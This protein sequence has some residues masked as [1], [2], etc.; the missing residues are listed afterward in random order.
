MELSIQVL[1]LDT[2]TRVD[3]LHATNSKLIIITTDVVKI[4]CLSMQSLFFVFLS[5]TSRL[6]FTSSSAGND[7]ILGIVSFEMMLF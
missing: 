4:G 6:L 5:A 7:A 1:L 3:T 2:S